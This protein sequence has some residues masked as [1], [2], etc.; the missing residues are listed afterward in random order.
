MM[1]LLFLMRGWCFQAGRPIYTRNT[2]GFRVGRQLVLAGRAAQPD[3]GRTFG[4]LNA[5][6]PSAGRTSNLNSVI[7]LFR[8]TGAALPSQ[9]QA[10]QAL[11]AQR[12]AFAGG[13]KVECCP[14][15]FRFMM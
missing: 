11:E 9:M 12:P 2:G 6:Q 14:A 10:G 5:A 4:S 13:Q 1:L 7:C 15:K 3:A 8:R